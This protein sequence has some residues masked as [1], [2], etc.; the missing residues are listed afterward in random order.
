MVTLLRDHAPP[1]DVIRAA[2]GGVS[3]GRAGG[4]AEFFDRLT[5]RMNM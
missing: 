5:A 1:Q 2:R 4:V 3:Y